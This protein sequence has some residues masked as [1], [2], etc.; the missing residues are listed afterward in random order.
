MRDHDEEKLRDI[1][2]AILEAKSF[3][4]KAEAAHVALTSKTELFHHSKSFASAKRASMD[5]TNAL[6]KMRKS[7]WE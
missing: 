4:K 6:T 2:C 3:V 5:L 7:R 1:E